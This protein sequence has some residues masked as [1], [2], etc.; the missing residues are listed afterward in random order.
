MGRFLA[1]MAFL[2]SD[3]DGSLEIGRWLSSQVYEMLFSPPL[4]RSHGEIVERLREFSLDHAIEKPGLI[5]K[6]KVII[7][8]LVFIT[9]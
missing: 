3:P 7:K 5:V 2:P 1:F 8:V 9:S 4:D 6:T